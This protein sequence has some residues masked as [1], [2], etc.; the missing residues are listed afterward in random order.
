MEIDKR[1]NLKI[2]EEFLPFNNFLNYCRRCLMDMVEYADKHELKKEPIH[3]RSDN[4]RKCV[5]KIFKSKVEDTDK[6]L[7]NNGY[8]DVI[9][10]FYYKHLFISLLVD[11]FNYYSASLDMAFSRN[12]NVAWALLRKPFQETLAYIEWLYVDKDELLTLMIEGNDVN[13]Y[14]IMRDKNKIRKHINLIRPYNTS[15]PLDM[16]EFRYSYKERET[17]N[18]MFQA[19]NHLITTSPV[20]KTFPSGLN[21]VF[22]ND[23]TFYRNTGLYYTSLPYIME[24]AM[25]VIMK[26]FGD[27]AELSDYTVTINYLNMM[28]KA[29][30]VISYSDGYEKIKELL[31]LENTYVYCPT[32]GKLHNSDEIWER[33]A[34]GDYECS[35]CHRKIDTHQYL[36]DFEDSTFVFDD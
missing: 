12:I 25:E 15:C 8:K 1:E 13:S 3:Y 26:I 31:D 23:E 14:E 17:L 27:I 29:F 36:F 5:E 28:L 4:D 20:L 21:F 9:Y 7:I 35:S 22:T 11:F 6:W 2:S 24:Y 33:F 10:N 30:Q 34:Y 32:C 18:G 16:F 19:T